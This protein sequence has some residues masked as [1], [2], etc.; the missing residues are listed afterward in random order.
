MADSRVAATIAES[1][2]L[3]TKCSTNYSPG[4]S[5]GAAMQVHRVLGPGFLEKVYVNALSHEL[6]KRGIA[7]QR[8]IWLRVYYDDRIVGEYEALFVESRVVVECKATCGLV[9]GNEAQ[10]VN[11]LSAIRQDIGLL[12]NFGTDRLQFKRKTR[13]YVPTSRP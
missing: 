6:R 7:F 11:R 9:E 2:P 3:P 8:K 5:L 13:T 10:V 12:L 1:T 4:E